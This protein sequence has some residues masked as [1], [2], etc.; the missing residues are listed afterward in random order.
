MERARRLL[1]VG[2]VAAVLSL[3]AGRGAFAADRGADPILSALPEKPLM[4]CQ[5]ESPL[6]F[7]E[8]VRQTRIGEHVKGSAAT[9]SFVDGCRDVLRLVAA[10]Y[11]DLPDATWE[12]LVGREVALLGFGPS[13]EPGTRPPFALALYLGGDAKIIKDAFEQQTLPR[14]QATNPELSVNKEQIGGGPVAVLRKGP[15]ATCVRFVGDLVVIGTR[16]AV[17]KFSPPASTP[18]WLGSAARPGG[19]ATAELNLE[20]LI[21]KARS[22]VSRSPGDRQ[23]LEVTGLAGLTSIAA[24]TAV[25]DGGFKDT[26]AVHFRPGASGLLPGVMALKPGGARCAEVV[27]A[28]YALVVSC[29]VESGE[30][31]YALIE[32]AVKQSAGEPGLQQ[33]RAGMDQ[34]D[35]AFAVN[36][37]WELLPRIGNEAFFAVR[38]PGPDVVT[39]GRKP[40]EEDFAPIF[41][42]AVKDEAALR[43]LLK[44]FGGSQQARQMGWQLITEGH[45]GNEVLTLNN[46]AGPARLSVAFLDGFLVCSRETQAVRSAISAVGAGKTLAKDAQYQQVQAHLPAQGNAYVYADSR[47]LKPLLMEALRLRARPKAQPFLPLVERAVPDLGGYGLALTSQGGD[48]KAEGYGDVPAAF[49]FLSLA[50]IGAVTDQAKAAQ[51]TTPGM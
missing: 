28:D 51:R 23:G 26:V 33:F 22:D 44:R 3:A 20:P 8:A 35:Q 25:E 5:M 27:P 17:A 14:L 4:V 29:Q 46:I 36:V 2:L 24:G 43:D 39:A 45:E 10:V 11:T 32:D 19:I 40:T 18:A 50:S 30:K 38:A 13:G 9:S 34:V 6:V 1:F 15:D 31:L 48:V 21:A 49:T 12:R 47:P 41:G 42:F 16:E 7:I 37:E